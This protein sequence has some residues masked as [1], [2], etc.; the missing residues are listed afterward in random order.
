VPEPLA[1]GL[2][3][4]GSLSLPVVGAAFEGGTANGPGDRMWLRLYSMLAPPDPT[5]GYGFCNG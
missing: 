1:I 4:I 3:A 2:F 5:R